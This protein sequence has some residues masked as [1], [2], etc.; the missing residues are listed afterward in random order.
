MRLSDTSMARLRDVTSGA[1]PD[2]AD[3]GG[4]YELL[5]EIGRGGMGVVY[6]AR[7]RVIDRD[8]ALKTT[9]LDSSADDSQRLIREART[10]AA[11]EHQGL[12]PIYDAGLLPDG[13]DYCAMRLVRGVRLDDWL[14][15]N[16]SFAERL[17]LFI[18]VCEPIAFAHAHD[19][20]HRDLKP[21]NIMVG[22]FG[23]VLVLDWG[24]A[25]VGAS[26]ADSGAVVG[27]RGYMAPEQRRGDPG[28]NRTDIYALGVLL[29]D[30]VAGVPTSERRWKPVAAIARRATSE[31]PDERYPDCASLIADVTAV[32]SDSP[33]SAYRENVGERVTRLL[34]KHRAAVA[35]IG[36]YLL[37]RL[38]MLA[39]RRD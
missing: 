1:A 26:R 7:D 13:R 17:M 19:V 16:P 22:S 3:D 37:V 32:L 33:V 12:V 39:A 9:R 36:M 24:V 27:T 23:D 34:V 2:A 21:S 14:R 28:D 8:V 11:L 15:G 38:L 5:E 18:R 29:G 4:R 6:R 31:R 30:V 35:V 20:I 10:A 25:A